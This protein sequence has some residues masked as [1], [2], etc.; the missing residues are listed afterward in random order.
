MSH[1]TVAFVT[2]ALNPQFQ[3]VALL[4]APAWQ[5]PQQAHVGGRAA[6]KPWLT[7]P[8]V[9]AREEQPQAGVDAAQRGRSLTP[10]RQA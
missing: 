9:H 10:A 4:V 5:A 1:P 3:P 7:P 6:R 2:C 8:G